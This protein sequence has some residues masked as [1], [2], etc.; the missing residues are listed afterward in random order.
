MLKKHS[1]RIYY[2]NYDETSDR[3][4]LGYIRGERLCIMVDAGSSPR[5]AQKFLDELEKTGLRKPDLVVLTHSHWDHTYGLKHLELP[6]IASRA[7]YLK[8]MADRNICWSEEQFARDSRCGKI[9]PFIAQYMRIEYA[10]IDEVQIELP[11]VIFESCLTLDCGDLLVQLRRCTNPHCDD[12]IYVH[13]PD[14]KVIF[15]GDNCS[16]ELVNGEWIDHPEKV[17]AMKRELLNLDFDTCFCSHF[18]P[19]SRKELFDQF[20]ER[21]SNQ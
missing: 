12:G 7:T 21:L 3:P 11:S 18:D 17:A 4:I 6:S 8:L 14:E 2:L 9:D 13:V 20:E 10:D 16:S 1:D 19:Y 15:M 5:H